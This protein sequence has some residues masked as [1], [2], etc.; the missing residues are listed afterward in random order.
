MHAFLDKEINYHPED[1]HE[2]KEAI[3]PTSKFKK[4]R[5]G[6]AEYSEYQKL[7]ILSFRARY[8]SDHVIDET[9]VIKAI[10]HLDTIIDFFN[11]KYSTSKFPAVNLYC[12]FKEHC[13]KLKHINISHRAA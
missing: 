1:H 12:N 13:G 9:H 7:E 6:N 11:R 4:T 8:K 10:N 3:A 2:L 5:L